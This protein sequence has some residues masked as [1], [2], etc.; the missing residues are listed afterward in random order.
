MGNE[1]KHKSDE[2]LFTNLFEGELSTAS[3]ANR[4]LEKLNQSNSSKSFSISDYKHRSLF[5][6][7]LNCT[8]MVAWASDRTASG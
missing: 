1:V 6:G 7:P 5:G 2:K 3:S 8:I 4:G